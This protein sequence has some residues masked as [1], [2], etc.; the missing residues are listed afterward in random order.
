MQKVKSLE[1]GFSLIELMVVMA[2]GSILML[3]I[4]QIATQQNRV[5]KTAEINR[6]VNDIKNQVQQWMQDPIVCT[7]TMQGKIAGKN[8]IDHAITGIR[9][10]I[11]NNEKALPEDFYILV[12]NRFPGTNWMITG[13]KFLNDTDVIAEYPDGNGKAMIGLTQAGNNTE[14]GI[15]TG[16]LKIEM[17]LLNGNSGNK[18]TK[19]NEDQGA[20]TTINKSFNVTFKG[21]FAL[22]FGLS[23]DPEAILSMD[24]L[25]EVVKGDVTNTICSNDVNAPLP[26]GKASPFTYKQMVQNN[27]GIISDSTPF[28]FLNYNNNEGELVKV[29][30]GSISTAYCYAAEYH[31]PVVACVG[32]S[33]LQYNSL[34]YH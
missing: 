14:G 5:A 2:I 19:V 24:K 12:N 26:D 31:M 1:N 22:T 32:L 29:N 34:N 15:T 33:G 11:S 23:K 9:R 4:A 18:L 6:Q 20:Y 25:T 16:V 17:S 13:I 3:A 7:N 10:V 30:Q 21:L 27:G 8:D 28:T